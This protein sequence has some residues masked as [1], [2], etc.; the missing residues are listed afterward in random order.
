MNAVHSPTDAGHGHGATTRSH[1]GLTV[2]IVTPEGL[3]FEGAAVSVVVPAHDGE[4]AFL[5]QHAAYVGALGYGELRVTPPGGAPRRWFLEGGVAE[6][7]DDVVT[8]LAERVLP[9]EK[10]DVAKARADLARAV[11]E[12]AV[13]DAARD[14]RDRA[15]AS[16]RARLRVSGATGT[17]PAAH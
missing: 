7:A 4:V 14:A 16:A 6:V 2:A 8:V 1:G 11:A 12:V 17:S 3:A 5:P 15:Q 13:G 10:I 9:V